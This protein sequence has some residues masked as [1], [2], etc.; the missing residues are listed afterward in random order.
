MFRFFYCFNLLQ[1]MFPAGIAEVVFCHVSKNDKKQKESPHSFFTNVSSLFF[2]FLTQK[3]ASKLLRHSQLILLSTTLSY[4][5]FIQKSILFIKKIKFYL[6]FMHFQQGITNA[7][8][9]N[10]R[11]DLREISTI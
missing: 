3:R 9:Y 6:K 10:T 8:G 1:Q 2:F 11:T 7:F 4:H 5:I